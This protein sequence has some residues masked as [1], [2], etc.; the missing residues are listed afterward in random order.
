M[1]SKRKYGRRKAF[2]GVRRFTRFWVEKGTIKILPKIELNEDGTTKEIP[3]VEMLDDSTLDA[4][5][6]VILALEYECIKS[7]KQQIT[8]FMAGHGKITYYSQ[9][10]VCAD[11]EKVLKNAKKVMAEGRKKLKELENV[12]IEG[13]IFKIIQDWKKGPDVE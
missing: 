2:E 5:K 11:G 13:E 6:A 8:Y 3:D 4:Y 10:L 9:N 1:A 12:D 7:M